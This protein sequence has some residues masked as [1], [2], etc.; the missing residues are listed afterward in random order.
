MVQ[1]LIDKLADIEGKQIYLREQLR[2]AI[3]A[4]KTA[5]DLMNEA[6]SDIF[7]MK[8]EIEIQILSN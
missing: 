7:H 8:Q 2:Q 1:E 4:A 6:E 3:E 5:M